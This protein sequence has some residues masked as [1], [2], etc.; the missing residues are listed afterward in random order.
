[1]KKFLLA[2]VMA[3]PMILEGCSST[4]Q[5]SDEEIIK[6]QLAVIDSLLNSNAPITTNSF[7]VGEIEG[8]K[9]SAREMIYKGDTIPYLVVF[10]ESRDW[11]GYNFG[12]NEGVA[13][14]VPKEIKEICVNIDSISNKVN[15]KVPNTQNIAFSSNCGLS[16]N[17]NNSWGEDMPWDINVS[18]KYQGDASVNLTKEQLLLFKNL[19]MNSYVE[20]DGYK[21]LGNLS[22]KSPQIRLLNKFY[23]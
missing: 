8:L 18:T 19:L 20:T 7:A 21:H 3:V 10:G 6:E 9:L 22:K 5:K 1:M 4:T 2:L 23:K 12:R 14:V 13:I 15:T 16:I 17:A 11:D